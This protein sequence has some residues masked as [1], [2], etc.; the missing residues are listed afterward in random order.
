MYKYD[1]VPRNA[2]AVCTMLDYGA[3]PDLIHGEDWNEWT[4]LVSTYY[5]V[6]SCIKLSKSELA[7]LV[8]NL[9]VPISLGPK[10]LD[11][12]VSALNPLLIVYGAAA[13]K[14]HVAVCTYTDN[15]TAI[16]CL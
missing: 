9:Q 12:T 6:S 15:L 10:M 5:R 2:Y 16:H 1:S 13:H 4:V 8:F 7:K 14:K 3:L 11:H